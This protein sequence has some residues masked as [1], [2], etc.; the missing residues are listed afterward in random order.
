MADSINSSVANSSRRYSEPDPHGEAAM[1]LVETLIHA[2]IAKGCL[3]T[4]DAIEIIVDAADVQAEIDADRAQIS[5]GRLQA[6]A[7]LRTL[8]VSLSHDLP[9]P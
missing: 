6:A 8:S 5:D 9:E 7:L 3:T 2:L 1:V 4:L